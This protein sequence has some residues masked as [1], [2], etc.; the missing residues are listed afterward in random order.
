MLCPEIVFLDPLLQ[1][2]WIYEYFIT[3]S[4]HVVV[5]FF[6]SSIF[7]VSMWWVRRAQSQPHRYITASFAFSTTS[8]FRVLART[9]KE[10]LRLC[11]F[12]GCLQEK[13]KKWLIGKK[14]VTRASSLIISSSR[15]AAENLNVRP[16]VSGA[17][18][19]APFVSLST[20]P[21]RK[22]LNNS[23]TFKV[24]FR[25]TTQSFY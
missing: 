24:T 22:W 25:Q 20:W 21:E 8:K 17:V 19:T 4:L 13:Q 7:K 1:G 18:V 15:D 5:V 3:T 6:F 16:L 2:V 10:N 14:E 9:K 11:F 12:E 23:R